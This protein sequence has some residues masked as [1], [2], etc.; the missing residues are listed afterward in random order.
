MTMLRCAYFFRFRAGLGVSCLC[1]TLA[2][3]GCAPVYAPSIRL[4]LDGPPLA[5]AAQGDAS[6]WQG[7]MDRGCMAGFGSVSLRNTAN[8]VVCANAMDQPATDKGRLHA[9][10]TCSNGD[11]MALVFRNLGP[12]QGMGLARINPEKEGGEQ[13]TLF[14]HP[15]PDEALRRLRQVRAEIA[16]ALEWKKRQETAAETPGPQ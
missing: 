3:A 5:V 12:D 13:L 4:A 15:S 10:L 6:S 1:L 11:V 14:Y 16:E 8:G 7:A 2:Q 9:D